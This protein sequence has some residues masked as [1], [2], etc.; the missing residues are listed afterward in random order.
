VPHT[1]TK[2]PTATAVR[3]SAEYAETIAV[4]RARKRIRDG[5]Y[6]R[7]EVRRTLAALILRHAVRNRL[8]ERPSRPKTP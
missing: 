3:D 8:T 1:S 2:N 6:D 7:P 4:N 5:Y